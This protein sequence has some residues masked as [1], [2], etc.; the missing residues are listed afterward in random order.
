MMNVLLALKTFHLSLAADRINS[1]SES[2]SES[3]KVRWESSLTFSFNIFF[4]D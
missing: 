1:E 2:E 4:G 3:E